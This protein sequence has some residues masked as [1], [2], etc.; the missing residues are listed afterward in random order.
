MTKMRII[1]IGSV[2]FSY[3]ILEHLIKIKANIV[4]VVSK[5]ESKINSDF[6]DLT[7]ICSKSNLPNLNTENINSDESF[8]WVQNLMPDVIYC[9]GWS[10]IIKQPLLNLPKKGIIGFHPTLLPLNRGRH[11]LIWAKYLGLKES[12]TS[13][14]IMDEG[15]DSGA[16]ISQEKFSIQEKDTAKDLYE[17]II[18][19][20]IKQVEKFTK[21][22]EENR[23]KKIPQPKKSNYWR[24]RNHKDGEINFSMSSK[25]IINMVRALT[26]PYPGATFLFN[27]EKIIVWSIKQGYNNQP[28]IEPGKVVGLD[29]NKIEVKTGDGSIILIDHTLSKLPK[30]NQ[31]LI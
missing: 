1:Y 24:K 23:E 26:R 18:K 14:F 9:F 30:L 29:K 12:G 21:E 25:T 13:F 6:Y 2:F 8:K 16:I 27:G 19:N 5:K 28:N 7:P 11:P 17:K 15:A 22:L 10:N 4:G 3:K 31:Y 20:S